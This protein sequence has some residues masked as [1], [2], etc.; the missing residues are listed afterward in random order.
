MI[1]KE[2]KEIYEVN[3]T[4]D[5]VYEAKENDEVNEGINDVDVMC[6]ANEEPCKQPPSPPP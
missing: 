6:E 4:N 3:E 2:N 5:E 1:D